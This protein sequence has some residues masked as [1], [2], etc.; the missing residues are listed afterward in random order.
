MAG[1]ETTVASL[2]YSKAFFDLQLQFAFTVSGLSNLPRSQG[3]LDYTNL[4][5]RFGLGR[6][7]DPAHPIWREYL[8]GLQDDDGR[9]WTYQFYRTRSVVVVPP[10][11][12][13]TFG[14]FSY[15]LLDG[16]RIRLHFANTD[17]TGMS[18]LAVERRDA[19]LAELSALFAHAERTTPTPRTVV[20]ASWL[21]NLE[22][23][24]R[25]F[26]GSYIATAQPIHRRFRYMPLWGQF[27]DWRGNLKATVAREFL[28][29][30]RQQSSLETLDHCFPLQVLRLEAPIE[31]LLEFYAAGKAPTAPRS[32]T[33]H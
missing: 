21:Y 26:P 11:V 20:G 18:P 25:L 10:N 29:R 30:L 5:I 7:F 13:A 3:L 15:A 16:D 2:P 12:V 31:H 4:Y 19:R 22:A 8:A 33:R 23:Y 28:D 24:R 1:L 6:Q 17:M 9:E 27:V 14:C 32:I